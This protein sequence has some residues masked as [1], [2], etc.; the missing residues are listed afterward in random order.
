MAEIDKAVELAERAQH[1]VVLYG[2]GV[3]ETVAKSLKKIS[4]K[5]A[6]I[7]LEPGV[8]TRA[9]VAFGFENGF[10]PSAVKLLYL[11]LGEE[12]GDGMDARKKAGENAF[13]VVQASF[14]SPLTAQADVVLPVAIWS[15]RSGSLTNTL[16]RVQKVNQAVEPKGEAKPDWE[17]L[18]L[19]ANKLGKKL[20]ASLDEI[21]ARATQELK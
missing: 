19:L 7:A 5:A 13:V 8:N 17:I 14:V 18:S 6:F 16:G 9:A 3:T 2:A 21:S 1:P 20:G 11:L 4:S 12:S 10:K 15:E